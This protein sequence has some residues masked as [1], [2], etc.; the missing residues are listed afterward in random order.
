MKSL[1]RI[2]GRAAIAAALPFAAAAASATTIDFNDLS[3]GTNYGTLNYEN[4]TISSSTGVI[5]AIVSQG[6][7]RI[8]AND[9]PWG[10]IGELT[11]SFDNA[12]ENLTFD[13]GGVNNPGLVAVAEVSLANGMTQFVDLFGTSINGNLQDLSSLGAISN[14]ILRHDDTLGVSYDNFSFNVAD[15]PEPSAVLSMLLG[16]GLVGTA[17]H[18]RRRA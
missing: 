10:C 16:L 3:S 14:L 15:V 2:A 7:A 11:V 1:T 18:R 8:C 9:N 13:I 17:I 12:V 4:T 6:D 5:T